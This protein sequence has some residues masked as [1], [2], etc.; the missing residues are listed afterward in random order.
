MVAVVAAAVCIERSILG[1]R[2]VHSVSWILATGGGFRFVVPLAA[3]A[4]RPI[5]SVFW[6]A[7]FI[8]L[9]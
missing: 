7:G 8:S 4:P 2:A 9:S 3:A 6:G 5:R 1:N